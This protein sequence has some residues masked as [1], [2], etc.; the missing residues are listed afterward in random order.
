MGVGAD[1]LEG[2]AQ[3]NSRTQSLA[4]AAVLAFGGV[5]VAL[6]LQTWADMQPCAWCV[7][8][9]L[10]YLVI[11]V[12][13]IVAIAVGRGAAGTAA[14]ALAL[15]ASLAGIAAALWQ[16]FVAAKSASCALT[17]ADRVVKGLG[18]DEAWPAM[19]KARAFCDEANVPLAGVPF[20]VWSAVL[21]AL[22]AI[23]LVRALRARKPDR[24]A[25]R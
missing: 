10:V 19:F 17:L 14:A 3:L 5:A 7:L 4:A 16:Q 23:L 25:F 18:L 6:A 11:G 15:V 24:F 2:H 20:A 9:R 12:L 13:A 1:H 21:Y 22:V 8:Q